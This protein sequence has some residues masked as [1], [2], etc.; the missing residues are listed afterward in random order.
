MSN[1]MKKYPRT[2]HLS[3]SQELH[4]DDKEMNKVHEQELLSSEYVITYKMDGGNCCLKPG[5]GVFARSHGMPSDHETFDYI[6]NVHYYP[7][8][9]LMNPNYWYFGENMYG[10]HSIEYTEL[11]DYFY[12]FG[13]YDKS[14]DIWLSWADTIKEAK[15]LS[16]KV[17]PVFAFSDEL[18]KKFG[19]VTLKDIFEHYINEVAVFG[20]APEGFVVRKRSSF[21]AEDFEKSIG[22]FVRQGHVQSDEHWLVNWK[23]AE[24]KVTK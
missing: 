6:K 4:S 23:K 9:H 19:T 17:V 5:R 18:I 1:F 12:L 15:R 13:I 24:L 2:F 21:K 7:K 3:F 14:K 8:E 16:Y 20:V 10:I 11:D 22:K